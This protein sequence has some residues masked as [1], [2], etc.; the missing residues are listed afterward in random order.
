MLQHDVYLSRRGT[1]PY[2]LAQRG[3][4]LTM[5]AAIAHMILAIGQRR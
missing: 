2:R 1:L 4:R 5:P 3:S